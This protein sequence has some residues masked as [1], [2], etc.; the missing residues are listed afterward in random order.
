MS[1]T[2]IGGRDFNLSIPSAAR[3]VVFTD[4]VAPEGVSL[5]NL[6]SDGSNYYVGWLDETTY[7]VS[8][9]V[10]GVK[11]FANSDSSYMFDAKSAIIN[12]N[13]LDTSKVTNMN[14]MFRNATC[15]TVNLSGL[16]VKNV[17]SMQNMFV[18]N[19]IKIIDISGWETNSNLMAYR[20]FADCSNLT[21]IYASENTEFLSGAF[22]FSN[23]SNLIGGNG[24]SYAS[25][26]IKDQS[27]ARIDTDETPG[28][29]TYK[30]NPNVKNMK[31]FVTKGTINDIANA[32][33]L[34]IGSNNMIAGNMLA[35]KI[36]EI[37]TKNDLPKAE[38]VEF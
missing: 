16:D 36:L 24:T 1:I 6:A 27:Y 18:S 12:F 25:A 15:E 11:V 34:K 32:I 29:F 8:S 37:E 28:Y 7:Y 17:T 26:G 23:C 19:A 20:M 35:E 2:L 13:N 33:R 22:M 9:Q 31:M 38:E 14:Y 5:T 10:S 4:V 30:L 21:T 3:S